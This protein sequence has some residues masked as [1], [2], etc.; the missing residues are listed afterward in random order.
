MLYGAVTCAIEVGLVLL[1]L[2]TPLAF[3]CVHSISYTAAQVLV[4]ALVGIWATRALVACV[5]VEPEPGLRREASLVP[6]RVLRSPVMYM[7][8]FLVLAG[9]QTI[10]LPRAIAAMLS[11]RR[12]A[13]DTQFRE[14][15]LLA[16]GFRDRE[17]EERGTAE[18]WVVPPDHGGASCS[19]PLSVCRR[20]THGA[21]LKAIAYGSVFLLVTACLWRDSV[22]RRLMWVVVCMGTCVACLGIYQHLCWGDKIYG[23]V[24]ATYEAAP[25]GPYFCRSHFAG[26]TAMVVPIAFALFA[27]YAAIGG[28]WRLS[29]NGR[30]PP[31]SGWRRGPSG[32]G[33]EGAVRPGFRNVRFVW[34]RILAGLCL[35]ASG[36]MVAALFMS[37]S[38]G[39]VLA[40]VASASVVVV[41]A[42]V[43]G[44]ARRRS[45]AIIGLVFLL[46]V[47]GFV[48]GG[49]GLLSRLVDVELSAHRPG[50]RPS[51]WLHTF[52]MWV[53]FPAV[54]VGLGCFRHVFPMY[55]AAHF[56]EH[57]YLRAH[58]DYLQLLAEAGLVGGVLLVGF[59]IAVLAPAVRVALRLPLGAQ[60]WPLIG[61]LASCAAILAHSVV[62]FN[63]QIPANAFLFAIVLGLARN[64]TRQARTQSNGLLSGS[65]KDDDDSI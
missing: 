60:S 34:A 9:S 59:L 41:V 46:L 38:R 48:S 18:T 32:G 40:F 47:V 52:R 21:L 35:L 57:E 11:P 29:E 31:D 36:V 19:V 54:G 7:C 30:R 61:V 63:L 20:A 16:G 23:F 49:R 39:G 58:C 14:Y 26:Y 12:V 2:T 43:K 24:E 22:T 62:D 15:P 17:R 28:S 13:I 45:F 42:L 33:P 27:R 4:F 25:F 65:E 56:G 53:D 5:T 37:Q 3:G 50:S 55:K 8:G 1:L 51:L 10:A 64:M 44:R 6:G